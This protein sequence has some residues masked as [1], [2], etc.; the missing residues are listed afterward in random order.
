MTQMSAAKFPSNYCNAMPGLSRKQRSLC[1]QNP[2][3][4]RAVHKGL[5]LAVDECKSQ[6]VFEKWNCSVMEGFG[7]ALK[8]KFLFL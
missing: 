6:F 3:A 4:T 7:L 1:F 5:R 2:E 8:G